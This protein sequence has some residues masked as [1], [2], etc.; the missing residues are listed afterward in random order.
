MFKTKYFEMNSVFSKKNSL[1]LSHRFSVINLHQ[2]S[3]PELFNLFPP[4]PGLYACGSNDP[5]GL[6]NPGGHDTPAF[7]AY[8]FFKAYRIKVPTR[9]T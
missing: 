9:L 8:L 5:G 7:R 6:K 4:L 1:I 3:V 2:I